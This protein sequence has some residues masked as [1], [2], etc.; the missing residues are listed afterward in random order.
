M[1]QTQCL[2][3]NPF[4]ISRIVQVVLSGSL[5]LILLLA[6]W[7]GYLLHQPFALSQVNCFVLKP[8]SHATKLNHQLNQLGVRSDS[9]YLWLKVTGQARR[10]QAGEYCINPQDTPLSFMNKM[11]KG[12][13][14]QYQLMIVPGMTWSD[15]QQAIHHSQLTPLPSQPELTKVVPGPFPSVEGTLMP[16]TY[17]YTRNDSSLSLIAQAQQVMV[18]FLSNHYPKRDANLPY[19][20]M[21]DALIVASLIEK[22]SHYPQ[23][24]PDIAGVIVKRLKAKKYLGIDATIHYGLNLKGKVHARHLRLNHPY[25]TYRHIGLPPTAISFPSRA[26]I[27]SA[28][29][30]RITKNWYFVAD[31]DHHVFASSLKVHQANIRRIYQHTRI[32]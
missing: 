13:V 1:G 10:L 4:V 12:Q 30:P 23:E 8:G 14:R 17:A 28:L 18:Q 7:L 19:R 24:Y 11:I 31:G 25:N 15:L 3:F 32:A 9:L 22:E 16:D 6:L 29:H 5:F 21:Y 26:A 27:L 20:D 2:C